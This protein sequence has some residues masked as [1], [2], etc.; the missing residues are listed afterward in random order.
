MTQV[1]T[2]SKIQP[3]DIE[4]R[5]FQAHCCLIEESPDGKPWYNDIKKFLQNREY[6]QGISKIDEKTLRRMTMNFYLDGEILYKRSFD[7]TLLRCLN[8]NEIKQALKEVHEGICATHAN[9]HTMAKQ[10]QRS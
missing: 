1:D 8:E 7:G 2:R 5:S 3:I 10:I 4:V 6:P 9:G